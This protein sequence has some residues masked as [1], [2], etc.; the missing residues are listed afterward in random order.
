MVLTKFTLKYPFNWTTV[1]IPET[2]EWQT[3]SKRNSARVHCCGLAGLYIN[4]DVGQSYLIKCRDSPFPY[5]EPLINLCRVRL[6]NSDQ[7]IIPDQLN[8]VYGGDNDTIFLVG[9][10]MGLWELQRTR[11][12]RCRHLLKGSLI[13]PYQK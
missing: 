13:L 11:E 5:C 1:W 4:L 8:S 7:W 2:V 6:R 9:F 12:I 3:H 10:Q